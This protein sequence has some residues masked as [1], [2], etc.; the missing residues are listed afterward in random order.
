MSCYR[1]LS[2]IER[3]KLSLY[4]AQGLSQREIARRLGRAPS[5]ISREVRRSKGLLPWEAQTA[6]QERRRRCVRRYVLS[7]PEL[8]HLVRF[9]LG[10][11]H[12]SPEQIAGRLRVETKRCVISTSTI[13]SALDHGLLRDT[14]RSYVRSKYKKIGKS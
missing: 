5:T 9:W 7:D 10:D 8:E 13:Y 1:H 6:Y 11:L 2:I 12:W 3:E 14:L 4:L